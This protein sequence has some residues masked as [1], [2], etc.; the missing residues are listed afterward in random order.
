MD[1]KQRMQ[2]LIDMKDGYNVTL[3]QVQVLCLD[4]LARIVE[5]EEAK[6]LLERGLR[7]SVLALAQQRAM[8][9]ALQARCRNY[10]RHSD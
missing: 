10:A 1:I 6:E 7:E 5:L 9:T 8:I 4:V 3:S 2:Q